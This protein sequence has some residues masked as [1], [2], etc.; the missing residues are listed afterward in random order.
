[1]L[2]NNI[3]KLHLLC[4]MVFS[5]LLKSI[6]IHLLKCLQSQEPSNGKNNSC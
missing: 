4:V 2:S 1:M 5:L 6:D 3:G